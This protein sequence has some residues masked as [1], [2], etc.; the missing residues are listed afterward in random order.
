MIQSSTIPRFQYSSAYSAH[1]SSTGSDDELAVSGKSA[2]KKLEKV[3]RRELWQ[4]AGGKLLES[5]FPSLPGQVRAAI[6]EIRSIAK[7]EREYLLLIELAKS[8][9]TRSL[10]GS[11]LTEN[12]DLERRLRSIHERERKPAMRNRLAQALKRFERAVRVNGL[13]EPY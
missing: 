8:A 13:E 1:G 6:P 10:I 11:V 9:Q 3:Y 5:E 7:S 2:Q 12:V 4:T